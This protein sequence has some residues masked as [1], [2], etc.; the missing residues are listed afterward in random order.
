DRFRLQAERMAAQVNERP[1]VG[2]AGQVEAIAA[3]A[4]R[5]VGVEVQG[6]GFVS[7]E[8]LGV[9]EGRGGGKCGV[10]RVLLLCYP[11]AGCPAFMLPLP[12]GAAS[13]LPPVK[14]TGSQSWAWSFPPVPISDA[15]E[16]LYGHGS[17]VL[18]E[19]F[20]VPTSRRQRLPVPVPARR[21]WSS[22]RQSQT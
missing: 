19:C 9:R 7:P 10:H 8:G 14:P 15:R 1:A 6:E 12:L 22:W 3:M 17:P 2:A 11:E 18:G 5:V 21:R 16:G 13:V 4:E 20:A